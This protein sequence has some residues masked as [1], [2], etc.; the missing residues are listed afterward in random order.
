MNAKPPACPRCQSTNLNKLVSRFSRLRSEDDALDSLADMADTI[1]PDDPKAIRRLMKEMAG[2]M[3]DGEGGEDFEGMMEE[4][5]EEEASGNFGSADE[6]VLT[7][8]G[9][10]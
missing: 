9:G 5:I 6:S 3:G 10:D 4:A 8:D 7:G 2:G 1:N